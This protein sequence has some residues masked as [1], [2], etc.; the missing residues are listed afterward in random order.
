[1]RSIFSYTQLLT[2]FPK[3]FLSI[4]I[5][6]FFIFQNCATTMRGT[7][8][9]IPVT[10]NLIGAKVLVDGKEM[11]YTPLNLS[12]KRKKNHIIRVEKQGY[13]PLEIRVLREKSSLL[14]V[15][16]NL[17]WGV[18][19]ALPGAFIAWEGGMHFFLFP[20]A[21]DQLEEKAENME[22]GSI[23]ALFGFIVGWG[24]AILVDSLSGANYTLHPKTLSVTL[25]QYREKARPHIILID[26]E[27]FRDIK[28]IRIKCDEN[29]RQEKHKSMQGE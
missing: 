17:F 24:G 26:A 23:L 18:V 20:F 10:S 19:G 11:G 7:S 2:I 16:G 8:Q 28:W 12:L 6:S 5:L 21:G 22:T 29:N 25:T 27:K 14:S 9:K 13:I 15:L 3:F 4:V 1:M